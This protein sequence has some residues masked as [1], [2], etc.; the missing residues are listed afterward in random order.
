MAFSGFSELL[1]VLL[2]SFVANP[3]G[4]PADTEVQEHNNTV[5]YFGH[6]VNSRFQTLVLF[7][8]FCFAAFVLPGSALLADST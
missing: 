6:E 8:A 7:Q 2:S 3:K 1:F 5:R 4:L